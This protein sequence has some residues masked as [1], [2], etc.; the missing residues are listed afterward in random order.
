MKPKAE[1]LYLI[2]DSCVTPSPKTLN[3]DTQTGKRQSI[4]QTGSQLL[5][6]LFLREGGK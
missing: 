6:M 1:L 4:S 3:S 5:Q 2:L